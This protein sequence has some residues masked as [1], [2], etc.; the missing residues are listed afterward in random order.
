MEK[1]IS[2]FFIEV[3]ES[4]TAIDIRNDTFQSRMHA[5]YALIRSTISKHSQLEKDDLV[6]MIVKSAIIAFE[7]EHFDRLSVVSG[8][9]RALSKETER[10]T[11]EK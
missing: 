3:K 9:A 5:L 8:I 11:K 2:A 6:E 4:Q 10:E 1:I 7:E